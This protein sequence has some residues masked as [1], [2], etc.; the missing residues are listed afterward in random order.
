MRKKNK[1]KRIYEGNMEVVIVLS[2]HTM[3][4]GQDMFGGLIGI[5]ENGLI[6]VR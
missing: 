6:N 4:G 5:H 3:S 2:D 1:I